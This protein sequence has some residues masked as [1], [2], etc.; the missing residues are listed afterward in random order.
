MGHTWEEPGRDI[1]SAH[2]CCPVKT[3]SGTRLPVL[4]RVGMQTQALW[5]LQIKDCGLLLVS[6][7][8]IATSLNEGAWLKLK[9]VKQLTTVISDFLKLSIIRKLIWYIYHIL[10]N[11]SVGP[12]QYPMSNA[13]R[14]LPQII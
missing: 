4:G 2:L 9:E 10:Y 12:G 11:T 8:L 13:L 1:I 5:S 7:T 14:S 3:G 6:F